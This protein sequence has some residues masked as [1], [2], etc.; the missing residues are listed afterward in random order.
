MTTEAGN[1]ACTHTHADCKE[2]R[3]NSPDSGEEG[4]PDKRA[5]KEMLQQQS[6]ELHSSRAALLQLLASQTDRCAFALSP[7][8]G[9]P[10]LWPW[11][12]QI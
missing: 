12:Q 2:N 11:P 3:P 5:L 9:L 6:S 7:Q 4:S 8:H 1:T 10:S